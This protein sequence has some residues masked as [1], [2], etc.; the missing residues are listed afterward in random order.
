MAV[1]E[2]TAHSCALYCCSSKKSGELDFVIEGGEKVLPIEIKSGKDHDR[3]NAMD[4]MLDCVDCVIERESFSATET[5]KRR[6]GSPI[7]RFIC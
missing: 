7:I 5:W 1:Q 4:S 2:L 3:H 6:T